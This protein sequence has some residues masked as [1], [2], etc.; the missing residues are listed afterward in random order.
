MIIFDEVAP[1]IVGMEGLYQ[2]YVPSGVELAYMFVNGRWE[3][4]EGA[5]G[6]QTD[7]RL[8]QDFDKPMEKKAPAYLLGGRNKN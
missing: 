6:R 1:Q 2:Y 8:N 3:L 5:Q 7:K 4:R